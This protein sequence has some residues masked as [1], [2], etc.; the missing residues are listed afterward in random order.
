M[1]DGRLML[2]YRVDGCGALEVPRFSGKGRG[3]RLWQATCFE[4]F[5][6][7]GA[8]RYREFNFS[9]SQQWALYEFDGY[10]RGMADSNPAEFPDIASDAGQ[11]VFVQTVFLSARD[12]A[13]ACRAGLSAVLEEQG[14]HKS[15]W[16]L[17]H[18]KPEPDFHDP[19][20]FTI[21]LGPPH[22]A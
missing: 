8:G 20:C 17:S 1:K 19:S 11:T 7:K 10:R 3:D 13:G 15:Y 14:G 21:A 2:R 4:L 16:A 5:L 9:P 6:D 12:L 18:H 22:S